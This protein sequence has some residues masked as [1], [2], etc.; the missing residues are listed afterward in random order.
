MDQLVPRL[1]LGLTLGA[2]G[3]I[4]DTDCLGAAWVVRFGPGHGH[5]AG[6]CA[7]WGLLALTLHRLTL[8][9]HRAGVA[10]A[11]LAVADPVFSRKLG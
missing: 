4:A 1:T 7:L 5:E 2:G 3:C 10:H 6:F 11:G 8:H 9:G